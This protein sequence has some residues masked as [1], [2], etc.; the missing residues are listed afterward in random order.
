M[1]RKSNNL[2]LGILLGIVSVYAFSLILKA[3]STAPMLPSGE[4]TTQK[5]TRLQ[6][7]L[8]KAEQQFGRDSEE[9]AIAYGILKHYLTTTA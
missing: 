5:Y 9:Y 6:N 1:K 4:T 3:K 2:G 8:K 7:E